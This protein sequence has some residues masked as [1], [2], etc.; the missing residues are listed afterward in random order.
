MSQFAPFGT[1][2]RYFA[3]RFV[4]WVSLCLFGLAA[5]ITLIQSVELYRRFSNLGATKPEVNF[6]SMAFLNLP[7]VIETIL[8]FAMLSGAMLC[9]SSWNRSNE[10]VAVR[11]FGQSVWAAL[12]PTL[13]SAFV[14]GMLFVTIVNPIAAITSSRHEAHMDRIFGNSD[15]SF[16]VSANG[17]WLRDKVKD[18]KLIIRGDALNTEMASIINPV[19]YFYQNGIHLEALYRANLM[20]LT[21][22]GWMLDQAT[23]WQNDGQKTELG[24]IILP[25]GLDALDLRQSGLLPQSISI[26][27]LPGFIL[28]LERAGIPAVQYRFQLYKT[29][30]V[31]LLMIGITML[32]ARATL[33]NTS[34]G[35]RSPL[36]LRGAFL[37]III[38]M[39]SYFMQILGS[40]LTVP[41]S[42]AAWTPAIAVSLLGAIIL[43]RT[44][45]S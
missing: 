6:L 4:S 40:S 3:L 2:F 17:I 44:D 36:F 10:F 42:V 31:P 35:K 12:G 16:S 37:T 33:T 20:Q 8:P 5:I 11:G 30:S 14:I 22:K 27:L 29:L 26:Y 7:T 23:R 32:G 41:M 21:D 45:E 25:T 13:F 9:F 34:R 19:I 38:F 28:S 15:K 18:G 24:R 43:A 39:F 1:L